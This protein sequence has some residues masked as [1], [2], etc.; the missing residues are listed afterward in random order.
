MHWQFPAVPVTP[1]LKQLI[2]LLS[3]VLVPCLQVGTISQLAP[4]YPLE[5]VQEE[6]VPSDLSCPGVPEF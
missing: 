1:R 3:L 4:V 5:Q 6:Q 2:W